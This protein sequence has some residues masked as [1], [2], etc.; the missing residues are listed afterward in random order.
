MQLLN[1]E[2]I[3]LLIYCS[4]CSHHRTEAPKLLADHFPSRLAL[5]GSFT[6]FYI[7]GDVHGTSGSDWSALPG[8]A[9]VTHVFASPSEVCDNCGKHEQQAHLVTST[10]PITS[11][12]LDYVETGK[13]ASM[14]AVDVE[15]FLIK[16]LKWRVQTVSCVISA[17][18]AQVVCVMLTMLCTSRPGARLSTRATSSATTL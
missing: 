1:G 15:P 12:L 7:I 5:N 13:L 8:L 17:A 4:V 3:F 11:L 6:I 18:S 9:G 14:E 2:L 10:S 16:N